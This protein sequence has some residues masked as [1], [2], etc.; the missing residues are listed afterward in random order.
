LQGVIQLLP[1]LAAIDEDGQVAD[2]AGL[3]LA[4]QGK[5]GLSYGTRFE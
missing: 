1:L 3:D 2:D 5:C 4:G